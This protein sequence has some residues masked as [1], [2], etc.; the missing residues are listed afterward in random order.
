MHAKRK[1]HI[2]AIKRLPSTSK[3]VSALA[4]FVA[5]KDPPHIQIAEV[6]LTGFFVEHNLAYST[7]DHL[8]ELLKN[9]FTDSQIAQ[10]I[11]LKRTKATSIATAVIGDSEKEIIANKLKYNK[12]S[13]I[14]DESTDIS[15]Q[16]SSCIVLRYYDNETKQIVSKFWEL[17]KIFDK[18]N[19]DLANEGATGKNLFNALINSF[20]NQSIPVTNLIGFAADG[21]SVMMG[22]KNSVSSRLKDHCP[23]IIVMKCVCHSAHLCASA[24]CKELPRRCEDLSRHIYGFFKSSAKRQCQ[25]AEFQEF[26][27][28]KPHKMLHPSQTRWLS[29]VAVDRILEQW[30]ALQLC[31][32]KTWLSEKLVATEIIFNSLNDPIVKLY[33]SFLSWILPKFTD[34]NN[35]FQSETVVITF[36]NDKIQ[37]LFR[38]ILLCFLNRDY[39]MRHDLQII[40]F[41]NKDFF[42]RN[43]QMYLGVRV[44][45]DL[46][47]IVTAGNQ[48]E[49][50]NFFTNCRNFLV[51][52]A[53]EI[54][55]RYSMSDPVL[56]KLHI[57][58]PE[59]AMSS[60]FRESVP[61]IFPLVD[62]LPRIVPKGNITLIQRIDD[63]WRRILDK[64]NDV[65]LTLPTD[66]FWGELNVGQDYKELSQ[67]VLD[68]L[69]IPHSNAQ[70]ER[71]FSHVN[72]MNTKVRNKLTIETVN[73]TLLAAQHIK[74]AGSCINYKPSD[75]MLRKLNLCMYK[76]IHPSSTASTA[77]PKDTDSD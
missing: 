57:L 51:T 72:L 75:E 55:K 6:K 37:S 29:L 7:V 26:L 62:L 73:G 41:E 43:N 59:N 63:Q 46:K 68:T 27:N 74:D 70:C 66:K 39:V 19:P 64:Y 17:S 10:K 18:S 36:L 25:F 52:S 14:T 8:T 58:N 15:T 38:D 53:R 21:C 44:L 2:E 71:V 50:N 40:D 24:A 32:T 67:F 11:S 61:S 45:N 1:K 76:K 47:K 28:L 22:D 69:C 20:E 77:A 23:D 30:T 54:K 65:D 56:S 9:I 48:S 31:F 12:F 5:K 13:V 3:Q 42:L 49:I 16:K 33:F 60:K 4:S 35:F 34:F